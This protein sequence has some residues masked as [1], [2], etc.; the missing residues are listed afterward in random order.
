MDSAMDAGFPGNTRPDGTLIKRTLSEVTD[1]RLGFEPVR[2]RRHD[3][4]SSRPARRRGAHRGGGE[5]DFSEG[6]VS[7]P[8]ED[9]GDI[10][11]TRVEHT[12]NSA[13]YQRGVRPHCSRPSGSA[14]TRLSADVKTNAG[15]WLLEDELRGGSG[16]RSPARSS[17][18]E[19]CRSHVQA[20]RS[21]DYANRT[22]DVEHPA[23]LSRATILSWVQFSVLLVTW[24]SS[25]AATID[26]ALLNEGLRRVDCPF[27][28]R[29]FKAESRGTAPGWTFA[30]PAGPRAT[31]G[32]APSP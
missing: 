9:A 7:P 19:R 30:R 11:G 25:G 14:L 22:V 20:D 31:Q 12:A 4:A 17:T 2:A 16:A 10:L 32:V 23:H 5:Y 29:V 21:I 18:W 13:G 24:R 1:L 6:T 8:R 26:D 28:L 27:S 3:T 15:R